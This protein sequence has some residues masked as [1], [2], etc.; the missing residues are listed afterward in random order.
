MNA[1]EARIKANIISTKKIDDNYKSV[2]M[3]IDAEV[4]KGRY[5][6]NYYNDILIDTEMRLKE[7]GYVLIEGTARQG[8]C[9]TII[10]W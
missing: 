7:E 1:K 10:K 4:A 6:V 9:N 8:E 2:K 5:S 3:N